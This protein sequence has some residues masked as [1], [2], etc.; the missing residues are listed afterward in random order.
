MT[1]GTGRKILEQK[2]SDRAGPSE[3][4]RQH[5]GEGGGAAESGISRQK[6]PGRATDQIEREGG[7]NSPSCVLVVFEWFGP[8]CFYYYCYF[9]CE[10]PVHNFVTATTSTTKLLATCYIRVSELDP[11]LVA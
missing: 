4:E 5:V 7:K 6:F 9:L 11:L 8:C 2:R 10:F 1:T 3:I